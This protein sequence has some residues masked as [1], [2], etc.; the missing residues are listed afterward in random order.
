RQQWPERKCPNQRGHGVYIGRMRRTAHRSRSREHLG[1]SE[2]DTWL[3]A[4][5]NTALDAIITMN[6][7]GRITAWNSQAES[8]FGWGEAE[9]VGGSLSDL[10]IPPQH[11]EAHEKG[12]ARFLVTGEG[13]IL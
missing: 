13:P 8:T 5:F 4:V 12:I 2:S 1:E 11:R 10:I 9:A 3:K 7:A 6:P